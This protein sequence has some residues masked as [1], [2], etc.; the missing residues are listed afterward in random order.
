MTPPFAYLGIMIHETDRTCTTFSVRHAEHSTLCY[1]PAVCPSV[2]RVDRRNNWI[3]SPIP[4]VF[5][6]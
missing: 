4:V 3:S 2:T 1:L 6:G 5:V